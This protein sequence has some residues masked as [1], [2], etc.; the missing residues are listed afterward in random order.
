M[1]KANKIAK[2]KKIEDPSQL[3]QQMTEE[4]MSKFL[5]LLIESN[6]AKKNSEE[7]VFDYRVNLG[8]YNKATSGA[9]II[10]ITYE[11]LFVF[12]FK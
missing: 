11:I 12:P 2:E 8:Y 6:K 7:K 4:Q 1:E 5:D 9:I 3:A 10:F